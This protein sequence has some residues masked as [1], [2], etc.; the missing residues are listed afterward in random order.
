MSRPEEPT[1]E[2]KRLLDMEVEEPENKGSMPAK[3][4]PD[5]QPPSPRRRSRS[6]SPPRNSLPAPTNTINNNNK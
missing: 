6:R 2:D 4:K 5:E 3:T 1:E